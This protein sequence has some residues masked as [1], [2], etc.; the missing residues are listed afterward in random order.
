MATFGGA[1][2]LILPRSSVFGYQSSPSGECRLECPRN[3]DVERALDKPDRGD[4]DNRK[5]AR[6]KRELRVKHG[7]EQRAVALLAFT[8]SAVAHQPPPWVS[9]SQIGERLKGTSWQAL[10]IDG[11]RVADPSAL[12]IEFLASGDT[13]RGQAGCNSFIGPFAS[14]SDKVT[15]GYLQQ[16]RLKCPPEQ[17]ALQR[18]FI[19]VLHNAWSTELTADTL[20]FRGRN[21]KEV[22]LVPRPQ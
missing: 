13:V 3:G 14:R 4:R 6:L 20:T 17:A 10:S 8:Q 7:S 11:H 15:M 5:G 2:T 18:E 1:R 16:S 9:L 21:G 12:T 22:V 19:Q